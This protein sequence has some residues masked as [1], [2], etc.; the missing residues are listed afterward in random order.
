[1][2]QPKRSFWG[3]KPG[4]DTGDLLHF[5][6]NAGFSFV[7]G[8]MVLYWGLTP[9]AMVLV[10]LS[11]WRIFAVQPRFWI[12][13]IKAN[14]VDV[15]VGISSVGLMHQSQESG[16]AYAWIV[17]YAV[18]LLFIKPKSSEIWVG[19]QSFT[20]LVL[21]LVMLF[22][23]L[24]LTEHAFVVSVLVWVV[25]WSSSRHFFSNFDEP[26]YKLLSLIWGLTVVQIAWYA[27]HWLQYY[28][29]GGLLI[30]KAALLISIMAA[31]LG[32]FYYAHRSE[33]LTKNL[34]IENLALSGA[35]ISVLLLTAGWSPV[36]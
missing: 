33:R 35:L 18:W 16:W 11:K 27:L 13:N 12:P 7:I 8:A 22:G 1:M 24:S 17:F 5:V 25:A 2:L 29:A 3:K 30:S 4:F 36:L 10:V 9:L 14:L 31:T 28:S 26:H 6:V 19:V 15:A 34:V 32:S 23:S 20:A 21:G